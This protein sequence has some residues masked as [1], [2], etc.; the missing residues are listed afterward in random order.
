VFN[1]RLTIADP[2]SP[3][4]FLADV[5]CRPSAGKRI[6]DNVERLGIEIEEVVDPSHLVIKRRLE[7]GR[8]L[9]R[10]EVG[11]GEFWQICRFFHN[12][13]YAVPTKI[14][15]LCDFFLG[16]SGEPHIEDALVACFPG[17]LVHPRSPVSNG[18][19]AD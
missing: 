10:G 16:I 1:D 11:F 18:P 5:D 3:E 7:V 2:I 6:H 19:L 8:M 17:V 4:P 9:G 14:L 15:R 13:S 12:V